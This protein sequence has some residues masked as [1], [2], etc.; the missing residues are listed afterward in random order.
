MLTLYRPKAIEFQQADTEVVPIDGVK[1][2]VVSAGYHH[3]VAIDS[4]NI[5]T[6]INS[7]IIV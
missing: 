3:N 7:T 4:G 1:F 2:R 6:T 5:A